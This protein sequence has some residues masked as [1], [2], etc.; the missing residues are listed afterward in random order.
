MKIS[1][2]PG[3]A[4]QNTGAETYYSCLL[5]ITFEILVTS[6]QVLNALSP[7]GCNFEP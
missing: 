2:D 5:V 6:C 4:V 7:A 1:S 3:T